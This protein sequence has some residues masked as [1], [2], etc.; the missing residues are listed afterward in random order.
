[1]VRK[2][3]QGCDLS[4]KVKIGQRR[5]KGG[6]GG[7]GPVYKALAVLAEMADRLFDSNTPKAH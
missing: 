5:E 4:C 6:R 3:P 1:M 7:G 2:L